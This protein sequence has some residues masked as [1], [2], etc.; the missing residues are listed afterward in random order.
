MPRHVALVVEAT[1]TGTLNVY[2]PARGRLDE[3]DRLA[4]LGNR[5]DIA[6]WDVAWFVVTPDS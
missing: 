2:D 5:V 1:A 3:L 4:F 6:G